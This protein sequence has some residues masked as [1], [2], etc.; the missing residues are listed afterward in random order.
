MKD[1]VKR[2]VYL[3]KLLH[4]VDIFEDG[5][6]CQDNLLMMEI[7][8]LREK[9]EDLFENVKRIKNDSEPGQLEHVEAEKELDSLFDDVKSKREVS[10]F[11]SKDLMSKRM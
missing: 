3:L 1:D 8:Q 11:H 5:E 7:F 4:Q 2:A 6:I 9:I 10:M